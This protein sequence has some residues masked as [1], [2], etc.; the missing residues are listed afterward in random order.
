MPGMAAT[1]VFFACLFA[2]NGYTSVSGTLR[3]VLD[4]QVRIGALAG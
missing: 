1:L 2:T 3:S 4:H